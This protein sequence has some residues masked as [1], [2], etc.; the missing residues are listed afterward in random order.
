[1]NH[2]RQL[3]HVRFNSSNLSTKP[4]NSLTGKIK[5]L[6]R[7]Y[8]R[9][10]LGVYLG[11]SL[12]DFGVAFAAVH[13]LGTE[14]IGAYEDAFFKTIKE[15]T[16]YKKTTVNQVQQASEGVVEDTAAQA[17]QKTGAGKASL[18]TE[19]V[20]AYGIH[21]ALFIFIRVPITVAITPSIVKGL[22]KRGWNIGPAAARN[23]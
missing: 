15:W 12:V 18:W 5:E 21:K 6:S 17:H 9:A 4:D 19:V 10:A 23:K 22:V 8:G 1:M 7:K 16:G 20:I 11:I 13:S 14:R 3:K 2:L